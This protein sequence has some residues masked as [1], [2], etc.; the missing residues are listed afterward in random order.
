MLYSSHSEL[1]EQPKRS[2]TF[3]I[4]VNAFDLLCWNHARICGLMRMDETSMLHV[5]RSLI[6]GVGAL[7]TLTSFYASICARFLTYF[8]M[9]AES[10]HSMSPLEI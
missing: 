10:T 7:G 3:L 8:D 4:I 6:V 1:E 5:L 2:K 9:R